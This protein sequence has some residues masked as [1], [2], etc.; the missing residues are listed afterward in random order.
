M[1]FWQNNTALRIVLMILFFAAG[2]GLVIWGWMMKG[3]LAGLIIMLVG[4]ALLV[5]TI[6]VYNKPFEAPKAPK[7]KK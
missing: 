3:E 5:T 6:L 1:G 2:L 4:V 7:I